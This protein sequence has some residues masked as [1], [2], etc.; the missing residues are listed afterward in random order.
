MTPSVR[1]GAPATGD[2]GANVKVFPEPALGANL[3]SLIGSFP[4]VVDRRLFRT[5]D[6]NIALRVCCKLK[7][8][9]VH[10]WN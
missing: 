2:H 7:Y 6:I 1:W 10:F 5:W 3:H 4:H 9:A 8:L